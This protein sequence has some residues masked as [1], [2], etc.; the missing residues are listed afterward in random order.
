[1][2]TASNIHYELAE[3]TRGL[4]SGGVA[5][6]HLLA[7]Q[8]GLIDALDRRLHLLK[9]HLPYH[10]SDHVLNIAYNILAGGTCLEDLE[11]LRNDEV[12][13]DALGAQRIPDPT[14]AGDFCR[15]FEARDVEILMNAINDVRVNVWRQQPPEFFEQAII[16]ADGTLAPTTGQCKQG[17]DINYKGQ[18]GYHPLLV[19]LANTSEPLYL[20]NRS[21]NRP[22]HE[23]AAARFDQAITLCKRAGFKSVLLR[24]DTD[25]TQ[26]AELD[27]WDAA[28]V[29]FIF[30]I[31]AMSNLVAKAE[32]LPKTAWKRLK[33]PA[34]YEV[35]TA[36]RQR[37][38]NVKEQIVRSREFKNIR[39]QSEQVAEF[40]YRPTL[41]ERTYRVVVIRKNL[42]VEKGEQVLFDDLRYFFY[43]TNDRRTPACEVVFSAND[44]CNQENLIEQLK[45]GA[46]AMQMPVD[47]LVSNWA[48]MV[49]A[50]LAWTLKAW[51][52]LLLPERGRWKEKYRVEKRQVLTM[53]FKRF[54]N[55][56]VRVPCQ[57][58]R[59]GRRLVYRLLAWNP[60]QAVFLRGV[61]RL[62]RL[63]LT[64]PATH[65]PLRC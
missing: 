58:A 16:E 60:W 6:L 50:S 26:T 2:F 46:R 47:N 29:R 42:S 52:A 48:Y 24:G 35:K 20:V 40:V 56:F 45:N 36:P 38:A 1:M 4:G 17:M 22:S 32:N 13:L 10:E 31:D 7:R 23:G 30:G 49:M 37:P 8:V 59:T 51:F 44:R 19:S 54:V 28:G 43:I 53:E 11:L 33:R 3:R 34:R 12:Y 21:G 57:V 61:D 55:A 39:L 18:W 63:T 5:G 25:F 15:R 27:R 9:V 64:P 62:R 41:C 65:R 14:T